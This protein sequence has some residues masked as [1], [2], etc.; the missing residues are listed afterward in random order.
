MPAQPLTPSQKRYRLRGTIMS[1]AA[2][3]LLVAFFFAMDPLEPEGPRRLDD[4]LAV[5]ASFLVLQMG[6]ITVFVHSA[7]PKEAT[8]Q[9]Q[10][11][12][13]VLTAL[14]GGAV[15]LLPFYG[16]R[17]IDPT[18][19]FAIILVLTAVSAVTTW[20]VWRAA[21]ELMRSL[22]RDAWLANYFVIVYALLI[23]AAGERLGIF[24]GV[25]AWGALAVAT[26]ASVFGSS[27]VVIRRGLNRPPTDE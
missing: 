1:L 24:G 10:R 18:L 17:F 3:A 16:E 19:N 15:L 20:L 9:R 12:A 8:V 5:V 21:D 4:T 14:T 26:I 11:V 2:A 13:Q 6:L 7:A 27:W 25:T 22:M 23:Y